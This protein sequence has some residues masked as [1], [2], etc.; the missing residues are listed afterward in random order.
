MTPGRLSVVVLAAGDGKRLG[1]EVPK[2]LARLDGRPLLAHVMNAVDA[3]DHDR[4]VVVVGNGADDVSV[5]ALAHA[6]DPEL[7]E[8]ARQP[9]RR[10]TG[11]AVAVGLARVPERDPAGSA[12][13]PGD[14]VVVVPA[15]APLLTGATLRA[16]VD[17]HRRCAAAPA[18]TLLSARVPRP[19]G[20]GRIVR[21][22]D[23]TVAAVVEHRDADA[24]QLEIDEVNSSVYCFSA[25][26]LRAALAE[27]LAAA[28]GP[29]ARGEVYLTDVVAVLR[30]RGH[31]VEAVV[32]DDPAEIMGV[33]DPEQLAACETELRRRAARR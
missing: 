8:F 15:D 19:A 26:P 13:D 27:V 21:D 6:R 24:A 32:A 2:P 30:R 22:A 7:V 20:Y 33:N 23:G 18:A 25:S 28:A 16:L 9:D 17:R 12:A 11:D 31:G 29:A 10:G 14:L 3:L 4:V 1:G 5:A